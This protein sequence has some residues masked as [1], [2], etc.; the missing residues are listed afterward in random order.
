MN[1]AGLLAVL[2]GLFFIPLI[3]FCSI[4]GVFQKLSLLKDKLLP[5]QM[6]SSCQ[7]KPQAPSLPCLCFCVSPFPPS[8]ISFISNKLWFGHCPLWETPKV[9]LRLYLSYKRIF[10]GFDN[11]L[12]PRSLW[13]FKCCKTQYWRKGLVACPGNC[14][15]LSLPFPS[16]WMVEAIGRGFCWVSLYRWLYGLIHTY[17]LAHLVI[18]IGCQTQKVWVAHN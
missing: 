6:L 18:S 2:G 12:N 16:I 5:L 8:P 15:S 4:L 17:Q 3:Q 1:R 7:G 14:L 11:L 9:P 10:Q 13:P